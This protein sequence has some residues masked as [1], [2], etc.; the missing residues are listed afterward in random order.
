MRVH[1][2]AK[3]RAATREMATP[4]DRDHQNCLFHDPYNHTEN[5]GTLWMDY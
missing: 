4:F 1:T 5:A 3:N 2:P